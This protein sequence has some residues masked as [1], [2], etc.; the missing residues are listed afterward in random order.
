MADW[1]GTPGG[2][3]R[4]LLFDDHVLF[5]NGL[6]R[7]LSLEPDMDVAGE[8][9]TA[10]EALSMIQRLPVDVAVMNIEL[11][12]NEVFDF[13]GGLSYGTRPKVVGVTAGITGYQVHRLLRAGI[14]GLHLKRDSLSLLCEV[15]RRLGAGMDVLDSPWL[16]ELLDRRQQSAGASDS[17]PLTVR[18]CE[19]LRCVVRG[20]TSKEIAYELNSTEAAVKS[21]IQQLFEKTGGRS[22][23][24][25]VRLAMERFGDILE[26]S[27]ATAARS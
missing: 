7:A 20:L 18:E 8:A 23:A 10:A 25:L 5:R 2:R 3:L 12:G 16:R 15:I 14:D 24:Q 13:L 11:P 26:D 17:K 4:L 6:S 21:V 19:V 9:D 27:R 22:R 1:M